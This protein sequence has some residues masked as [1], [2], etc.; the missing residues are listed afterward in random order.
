MWKIHSPV[1]Y[2][3]MTSWRIYIVNARPK[4]DM[5]TAVQVMPFLE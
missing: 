5:A 3:E 1:Q 4:M 2:Y